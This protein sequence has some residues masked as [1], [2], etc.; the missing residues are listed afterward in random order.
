VLFVDG[1]MIIDGG[2][3]L[4][5]G[6]EGEVDLFVAGS[7]AVGAAASFGNTSR[8]SLVRTYVG[9]S[10]NVSLSASAY[11]LG[12]RRSSFRHRDPIG[13]RVL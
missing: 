2:M 11:V 6:P 13:R 7:L 8:P 12:R 10:E 4:E 3:N 1:D 5:I 9:G